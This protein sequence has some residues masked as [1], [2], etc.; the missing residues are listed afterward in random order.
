MCVCV[1]VHAVRGCSRRAQ[2]Y[3][4]HE[5]H[6]TPHTHHTTYASLHSTHTT[7]FITRTH[8]AVHTTHAQARTTPQLFIQH[9]HRHA[10]APTA[11]T[12]PPFSFTHL[13]GGVFGD[14][15]MSTFR[16]FRASATVLSPS[17]A[18]FLPP[19]PPLSSRTVL[20]VASTPTTTL[21]LVLTPPMVWSVPRSPPFS[22]GMTG[23]PNWRNEE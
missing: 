13:A 7:V 3:H 18:P 20:L 10:Q 14:L 4:P 16:I 11:P 8:N 23:G 5:S 21:S 2:D 12:T 1:L 17:P 22:H 6:K 15:S 9:T 19:P